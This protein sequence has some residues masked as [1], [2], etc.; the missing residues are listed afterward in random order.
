MMVSM[1]E[2]KEAERIAKQQRISAGRYLLVDERFVASAS[3]Q[4]LVRRIRAAAA[5]GSEAFDQ[6]LRDRDVNRLFN[7]GALS[8][9]RRGQ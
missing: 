5:E 6:L 7:S 3:D 8:F 1:A 2:A 4:M 9:D